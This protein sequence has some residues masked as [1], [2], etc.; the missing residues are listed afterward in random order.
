MTRIEIA[1][2]SNIIKALQDAGLVPPL[3]C[4][5]ILDVAISDVVK[6]Y[7]EC[8]ADGDKLGK[9]DLATLITD[10]L[11]NVS[12]QEMAVSPRGTAKNDPGPVTHHIP[13]PRLNGV[14]S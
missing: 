4:R 13:H 10:A 9:V 5:I 7:Y 12:V 11:Q 14:E 3:C 1:N 8:Y 2:K 6:L